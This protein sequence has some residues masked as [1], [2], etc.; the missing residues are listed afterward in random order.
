MSKVQI[1]RASD[2]NKKPVPWAET[3]VVGYYGGDPERPYMGFTVEVN[4][5]EDLARVGN[6]ADEKLIVGFNPDGAV[7]SILVYDDYVE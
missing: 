4:T 1:S 7:E 5:L 3:S 6:A 2:G